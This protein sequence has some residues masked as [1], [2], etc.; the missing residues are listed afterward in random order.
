MANLLGTTARVALALGA[1]TLAATGGAARSHGSHGAHGTAT[2]TATAGA[3]AAVPAATTGAITPRVRDF[4]TAA[5][6]ALTDVYPDRVT[7]F[8]GGVTGLADVTYSTTIGYRPQVLDIYMPPASAGTG[9]K[10]LILYIHGGGW[11]AGHT[12]H[13][14]ALSNF[15]QV[16]AALAAEGFVVASLEYRLSGE[17]PFPAQVQDSR[18]ALRFLRANASRFG[19]DPAR[20]G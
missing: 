14:G 20:V 18:A 11:I 10:P 19:L 8:P 4:P 1:I 9:P 6:P 16:L 7:Q 3:T 12:R 2:A 17:A 13:N 15:P 5:A